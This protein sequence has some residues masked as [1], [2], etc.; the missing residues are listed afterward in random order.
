MNNILQICSHLFH[1][2][3]VNCLLGLVPS[4]QSSTDKD[5][6]MTAIKQDSVTI[7]MGGKA[8][9]SSSSEIVLQCFSRGIPMPRLSWY[10]DGILLDAD[11]PYLSVI[12]G[13]LTIPSIA[14]TEGGVFTCIARNKFGVD[15]ASTH[16]SVV[17][18]FTNV[19]LPRAPVYH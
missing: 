11:S 4:I 2:N 18:K 10:K 15:K 3:N 16:L 8:I 19:I 17:G 5:S 6:I 13:L 12:K 9:V 14:A 7:P 1:R